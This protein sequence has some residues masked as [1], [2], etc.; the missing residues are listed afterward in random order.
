MGGFQQAPHRPWE[1]EQR[2]G[3][4][5]G[6]LA[7]SAVLKALNVDLMLQKAS[8]VRL[9]EGGYK[10]TSITLIQMDLGMGGGG[11][12]KEESNGS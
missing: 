4:P 10:K 3:D 1:E 2:D 8:P 6:P 7:L 12:A 11:G 5:Q 9:H